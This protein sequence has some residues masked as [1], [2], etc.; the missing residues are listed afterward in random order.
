MVFLQIVQNITFLTLCGVGLYAIR[1]N[2]KLSEK[3]ILKKTL[4]G[5][6][7]SLVF[8]LISTNSVP[9]SSEA[10]HLD[11]G[12]GPLL[13][14]GYLGG[15]VGA[16][17][18]VLAG[19]LVAPQGYEPD[20]WV[21]LPLYGSI[22]VMGYVL[23]RFF[24]PQKDRKFTQLFLA[25]A[26]GGLCLLHI[27]INGV[28]SFFRSGETISELISCLALGG[29]SILATAFVVSISGRVYRTERSAVELGR[30]L[31]MATKSGRMGVFEYQND[32]KDV[33]FD[34]GMMRILELPGA[35]GDIPVSSWIERV[36]PDD[37]TRLSKT[38]A[39]VTRENKGVNHVEFRGLMP[40]GSQRHFASNWVT[41]RDPD[42]RF[43]RIVGILIDL[44]DFKQ[45]EDRKN[46]AEQRLASIAAS[47]PGA[48]ISAEMVQ[49]QPARA[50]YAS[51]HVEDIWGYSAKEIL[52][53]NEILFDSLDAETREEMRK[54]VR[55]A[56]LRV[57]P[58]ARRLRITDKF[59]DTKWIDYHSSAVKLGEDRVRTD[60]I[61]FDVTQE[62]ADGLRLKEQSA[63]AMQAQKMESI[64]QLTGGVAHDFN[65]LLAV[66]IGNLE[67]LR[68]EVFDKDHRQM[69]EAG[70]A[71]AMRGADLT[72]KMLAFARRAR[73]EPQAI[74]LNS[75]VRETKN[76]AGRTLPANVSIETSL[77]AG[78]WPVS[79][80][81]A[82]TESAL[83]NLILN[84]R[85]AMP[86]GGELTLE[87]ANVRIDD[88]YI[89]TRGEQ[90]E[91]GRYVMLC[92]SDT[93]TGIEPQI[94]NFVFEPFY[95]TKAPGA[96][97]GLGLSMVMGFMR[98][99]GGTVRAYSEPG[100]GT[101]FKLYFPVGE[102]AILNEISTA[103]RPEGWDNTDAR[104]LLA[105][106]Q[107]DVREIL[108][109]ILENANYN[110]TP[111]PSGDVARTIFENDPSFDLLLT[112][113]V[114]P[115][116]LQGTTLAKVLRETWPDLRVV[117]MSGYASEA[118]VH[119]NGL[120]PEDIRLMKPIQKRDLLTAI[121]RV[122]AKE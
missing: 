39:S 76:W 13:F 43:V 68:D 111:A 87:T 29:L 116:K 14:A 11:G 24:P 118:T 114:M 37:R 78:L 104:I 73:L 102:K 53:N 25:T 112:D 52:A 33:A 44:T 85:D 36:H 63:L 51:A 42:G 84:A 69:I 97:S 46:E 92:V 93:G 16:A 54:D 109:R 91:P 19:V 83:L 74:D 103:S 77:L 94:L 17:I 106:D 115:G 48:I 67:L 82:S 56:A 6:V 121:E 61:I 57:Q 98:Q 41:D 50:V 47:L 107:E 60:C 7:F 81:Q 49:G 59:G 75:I 35:A 15:P 99:S 96:G 22:A 10:F 30:R 20:A 72:K 117:F 26:F 31:N 34:E 32:C 110:V 2:G 105:E 28:S 9:H 55:N 113:I 89:D 62:V 5:L 122:L 23:T 119:G 80:D 18:A 8:I 71:A 12:A 64:G 88:D 86:L 40:D 65:N 108:V 4:I 45:S 66:I 38:I 90:L 120:R 27:L 21:S 70:I 3:P 101:T 79:A 58:L 100:V 1:A 95:T